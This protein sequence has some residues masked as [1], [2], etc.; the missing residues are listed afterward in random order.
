[1]VSLSNHEGP[2]RR[3]ASWFDPARREAS[4]PVLTMKLFFNKASYKPAWVTNLVFR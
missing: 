2:V 4:V 1:M 3:D